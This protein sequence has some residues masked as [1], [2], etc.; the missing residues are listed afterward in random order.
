MINMLRY[1]QWP[2]IVINYTITKKEKYKYYKNN[3]HEQC[4][5][6]DAIKFVN[7]INSK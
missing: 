7:S 3:Y 6:V 5:K 1:L 2:Q 4:L